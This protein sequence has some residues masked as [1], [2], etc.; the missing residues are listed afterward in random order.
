MSDVVLLFA[1]WC[2]VAGVVCCLLFAVVRCASFIVRCLF[3][4][5][6]SCLRLRRSEIRSVF[7]VR[8]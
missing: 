6:C 3:C 5:G 8:C 4:V 2:L 7:V 1:V